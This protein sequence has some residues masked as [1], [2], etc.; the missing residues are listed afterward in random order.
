MSVV[1]HLEIQMQSIKMYPLLEIIETASRMSRS[2]LLKLIT[3][4]ISVMV[5]LNKLGIVFHDRIFG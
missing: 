3:V 4:M 5:Y 1:S 2:I